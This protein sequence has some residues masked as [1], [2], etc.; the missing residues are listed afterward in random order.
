MM[1]KPNLKSESSKAKRSSRLLFVLV[2][3]FGATLIISL[4]IAMTFVMW[5]HGVEQGIFLNNYSTSVLF[6]DSLKGVGAA[7]P[8]ALLSI[9]GL[10][11]K[12]S[13]RSWRSFLKKKLL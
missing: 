5:R 12:L 9:N 2:N 7:A 11:A 10:I 3:G 13:L 8:W 6:V 1:P 4:A